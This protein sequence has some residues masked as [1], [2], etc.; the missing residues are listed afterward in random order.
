[1]SQAE[2]AF[3]PESGAV[4]T[5]AR[6]KSSVDKLG[7]E[8][9]GHLCRGSSAL[10]AVLDLLDGMQMRDSGS[11]MVHSGNLAAMLWLISDELERA[12]DVI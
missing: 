1:M 6:Q 4:P 3:T 5:M 12:I 7:M 8:S 10:V 11:P 9:G 2:A